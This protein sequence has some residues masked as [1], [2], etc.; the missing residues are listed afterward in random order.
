MKYTYII[1]SLCACSPSLVFPMGY[2]SKVPL[3]ASSAHYYSHRP[4]QG[5]YDEGLEN[6]IQASLRE[7][8]LYDADRRHHATTSFTYTTQDDIPY[9]AGLTQTLKI[10]ISIDN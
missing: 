4:Q 10:S 9:E 5:Q 1:A 8:A 2:K 7:Q 3:R 6:A